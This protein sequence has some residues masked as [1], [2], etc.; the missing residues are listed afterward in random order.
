MNFTIEIDDG[1]VSEFSQP[2]KEELTKVLKEKAGEIIDEA[3]RLEESRRTSDSKEITASTIQD[4]YSYVNRFT[5]VAKTP[6]YVKW[7]QV[8]ATVSS[9]VAGG[10]FDLEDLKNTGHLILFLLVLAVAV[11]TSVYLIFN[12]K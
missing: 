5:P 6:Q 11:G 10:L 7:V 3:N 9:I 12:R 2:A 8:A 1:Q 4:A